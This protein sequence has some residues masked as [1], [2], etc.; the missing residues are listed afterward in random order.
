MNGVTVVDASIPTTNM[1]LYL[2][3]AVSASY[4]G[5]GST[6]YDISGNNNNT[7]GTSN[8]AYSS[9]NGGYFT[10]TDPGWFT[11]SSAKY[12]TTYTGKSVFMAAKLT[13]AMG[14]G[15]YRC[16][17]GSNGS[18]RNFNLYFYYTGSA[19]ELHFSQG[20]GAG[21]GTI[22]SPL[23][24]TFGNWFTCGVTMTTGGTITYYFNGQQVNTGT[25]TFY[26]YQST[27]SENVG[28]SD[29]YWSGP[30]SVACIY[31]AA[32]S[33]AQMLQAHNAVRTRYSLA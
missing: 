13:G 14:S 23:T 4:P 30:I 22:S 21:S 24:Y 32:L 9:S 12:N 8:T 6:W 20:P 28:A 25:G 10:F 17:F 7:T 1:L 11:T 27:T 33:S 2:D 19:Y 16:L 15:T 31:K 29:N 18:N 26:Q 5:T 3:A